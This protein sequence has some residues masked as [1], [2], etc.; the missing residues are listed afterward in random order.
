MLFQRKS[1]CRY[2]SIVT[3]ILY[4]D[5]V[6]PSLF[7][8]TPYIDFFVN[9]DWSKDVVITTY[10]VLKFREILYKSKQSVNVWL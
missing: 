7:Y 10:P 1:G 4:R 2:H 9:I 5:K 8:H 3:N 6:F